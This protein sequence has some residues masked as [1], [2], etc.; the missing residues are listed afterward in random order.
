[1]AAPVLQQTSK[2]RM[3]KTHFG[4]CGCLKSKIVKLFKPP[5]I[6]LHCGAISFLSQLLQFVLPVRTARRKYLPP[7]RQVA[8]VPNIHC[9]HLS[10]C[11]IVEIEK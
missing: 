7:L 9:E 8:A 3:K 10:S 2:C 4:M 1:M 6:K 11:T 5:I